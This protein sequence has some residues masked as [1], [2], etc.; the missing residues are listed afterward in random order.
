MADSGTLHGRNSRLYLGA[1]NASPIPKIS[2][3]AGTAISKF[4][5]NTGVD[6]AEDT[7]QG[8]TFKTY[9]PG[10]PDYSGSLDFFF[11]DATTT[12]LQYALIDAAMQGTPLK[13]YAYPG[14][15]AGVTGVYFYG[16]VYLSLKSLP[17]DVGSLV[18]ASFDMKAAGAI[19]FKHP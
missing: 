11:Q 4:E 8:D 19:T 15:G 3:P 16:N 17:M 14:I 12:N 6:F 10:L 13:H 2:N 1:T 18:T 5:V 9:V 7:A